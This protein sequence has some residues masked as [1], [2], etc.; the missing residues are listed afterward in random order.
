M[1]EKMLSVS[2][3]VG[4]AIRRADANENDSLSR[5]MDSHAFHFFMLQGGKLANWNDDTRAHVRTNL[6]RSWRENDWV[7][8]FQR[9]SGAAD[10]HPT[11][12]SGCT[13]EIGNL[14]GVNILDKHP[15]AA[16]DPSAAE[17]CDHAASA[18]AA[19]SSMAAGGTYVTAP[20]NP[21]L[22]SPNRSLSPLSEG[23]GNDIHSSSLAPL[24]SASA[25]ALSESSGA[26]AAALQRPILKK[27]FLTRKEESLGHVVQSTTVFDRG[28]THTPSVQTPDAGSSAQDVVHEN[29]I[30]DDLPSGGSP[31]PPDDVLARAGHETAE[32]SA[33]ATADAQSRQPRDDELVLRDRMLVRV[34]H[35]KLEGLSKCFDEVQNRYTSKLHYEDWAEF[36]VVWRGQRIEI[37]EDYTTP[38]KEF[39]T[40]HKK[41]AFLIP[42]TS[43]RTSVS[44]YSFT[45]HTFC[46]LCPPTSTH[47]HSKARALFHRSKEGTNVFIFK[48]KSRSRAQDW[49]WRLWLHLGGQ[50]P[51]S[52]DISCPIIDTRLKLDIAAEDIVNL[53]RAYGTFSVQKIIN[54]VRQSMISADGISSVASRDWKCVIEQQLQTGKRLEL[55]WRL[56][57]Q[58]DWVWQ[59][60][61]VQGSARPWAVLSGLPLNQGRRG[62]HLE[63]RIAEHFPSLVHLPDGT[64]MDEPPGVEGYLD[65][66]KPQGQTRQPVYISTRDGNLVALAPRDANPPSP[67][68]THL[69]Y[70]IDGQTDAGLYAKNL[71]Q[72]EVQR[73][74]TQIGC[75][76]GV[77][78]LKNIQSVKAAVPADSV[79]QD[80]D[81]PV[82]EDEGGVEGLAKVQ[83][84]QRLRL[85]R[86]FEIVLATGPVI[87]MEAYSCRDCLEW[88][89]KLQALII[90]WTYR[91]REDAA[92]EM[93]VSYTLNRRPR[94]TPQ[95][96]KCHSGNSCSAPPELPSDSGASLPALASLYHWCTLS[97]CKSIIKC[98]RVFTRKGLRGQYILSHLI[99]VS[100]RLIQFHVKQKAALY[101]RLSR[102]ICLLDAYVCSGY[103][104]ALALPREEFDL[105][106]RNPPRRYGDGLE[107]HEPEEDTLF[108]IWY[109]KTQNSN[110]KGSGGGDAIPALSAKLKT[111]VFRTRNKVE[112]DAWCWALGCEIDKLVRKNGDREH[113][114][115][116]IGALMNISRP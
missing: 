18:A 108:M 24:L 110:T 44:L 50:I 63:I 92:L 61:D 78:D 75:A 23:S 28:I 17:V 12:W 55:N 74:A 114:L 35:T 65:R 69:A 113:R 48:V 34:S 81:L 46:I 32:S 88:V 54:L 7:R 83:N 5:A 73:G 58:L 43:L 112:R 106:S 21:C 1:P 68:T 57:A 4:D 39:F 11:R 107:A 41:L 31:A 30:V 67:P 56:E 33:G 91:H 51:P 38:G 59:T 53:D 37:Y 52:I 80:G 103:L 72:H 79:A 27:D 60:E 76:Y 13:F 105:N 29:Q 20:A 86:S 100:G 2:S 16:N 102:D 84:K 3:V 10:R 71:F 109:R 82:N 77:M 96:L 40:G 22:P 62:S 15:E 85:R 94:V 115:R 104:A 70:I 45:D 64:R 101:H 19:T 99:L 97:D 25:T 26:G 47:E 9:R 36:I 98:G 116:E 95:L 66:I 49:I 111:V 42:L 14:L 90:Y 87:H 6:I 8:R 89:D 93:D